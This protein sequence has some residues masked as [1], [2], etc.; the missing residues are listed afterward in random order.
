MLSPAEVEVPGHQN[1]RTTNHLAPGTKQPGMDW[2]ER[3]PFRPQDALP[4]CG[5]FCAWTAEQFQPP[6]YRLQTSLH[7]S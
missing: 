2:R 7:P 3:H 4:D 1:P 6:G 5:R